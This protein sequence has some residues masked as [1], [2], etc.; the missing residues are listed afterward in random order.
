MAKIGSPTKRPTSKDG[1][2]CNQE[3]ALQL[4]TNRE[5][6]NK[7][8]PL[9]ASVQVKFM[10]LRPSMCRWPIGDPKQIETFRFCGSACS[11]GAI[12]CKAHA[13]K[14]H[15]PNRPR[16]PRTTRFQ[17]QHPVRVA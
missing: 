10:E 13:A 9:A 11:A 1:F 16:T 15:A 17:L 3:A 12:Y 7:S 4:V 5:R 14:A 2:C 6:R 8:G